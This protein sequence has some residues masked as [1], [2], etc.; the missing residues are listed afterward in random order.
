MYAPRYTITNRILRSIGQIE[1]AKEIIENAPL[2]PQFEKQFKTDAIL[3]TVHHGTHIEGNDLTLEQTKKVLE[4]EEVVA[5]DRDIQEVIN[6]RNVVA[7][8]DDFSSKEKYEIEM[9]TDIQRLSVFRIVADNKIGVFRTT[10]VVIKN[11]ATGEIILRP[12]P[13][14]EVPYMVEDFIE[15]LNFD[16]SKE[17]HPILRAGIAHYIFIIRGQYSK[18]QKGLLV[19]FVVFGILEQFG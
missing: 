16:S 19:A 5:R 12:P 8:L 3:R 1:A 14:N 6:D 13:F 10:Q 15:W 7:L 18:N 4:G 2:V 9:L 11:E 17:I